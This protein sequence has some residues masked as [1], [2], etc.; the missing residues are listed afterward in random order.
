MTRVGSQSHSK[1]RNIYIYIYIYDPGWVAAP[2]QKKKCVYI[3]IYI[4]M[5]GSN[6]NLP[7][8]TYPGC[9][10]PEPY[11]SP[12]WALVPARPA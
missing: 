6:G 10:V 12:D 2:Q 7:L 8:R 5:G 9:S 1:K 3:Y 11:R 4:Y